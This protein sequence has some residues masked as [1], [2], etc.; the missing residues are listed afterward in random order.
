MRSLYNK[1]LRLLFGCLARARCAGL[2]AWLISR[3]LRRVGNENIHAKYT[4]LMLPRVVFYE[5]VLAAFDNHDEFA[6]VEPPLTMIKALANAFL[7]TQIDTNNYI[8]DDPDVV[9]KKSEYRAFLK[10]VWQ[11]L[12][13]L[14]PLHAV[15]TGNF[16]YYAERELAEGLEELGVPFIAM[17][18]ENL[19]SPGRIA[20]SKDIYRNRRGRFGGRRI[21]VYNDREAR[22]QIDAGVIDAERISVCGMPRLDRIHQWRRSVAGASRDNARRSRVLFF[23]FTGSAV[24]PRIPRRADAGFDANAEPLRDDLRALSWKG[25]AEQTHQ[26]IR[27][28]AEENPDIDVTVKSK[29]RMRERRE[30]HRMLDVANGLPKNLQ[31]VEGGDP[32][33][34]ITTADVVCGFNSTALIESLAAGKSIVIP[35]YAEAKLEHMQQYIV[36]LEDA[37]DY[38]SSPDDLVLRLREQAL[39]RTL[40]SSELDPA[41]KRVLKRWA[42]N[43]D[44]HSGK[45][46]R[47][48]LLAEITGNSG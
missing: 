21:L 26:A 15:V 25:L 47:D 17:H 10:E 28:L 6:I 11:R 46:V 41:R 8:S 12:V 48:T 1:L 31:L 23:S 36:D 38:A 30:M 39:A 18:K 3:T 45:R 5:D 32:F 19:K 2:T 42:G 20:F 40:N 24:L 14:R 13:R 35:R 33:D 16:A 9:R 44:G 37:V 34:L 7:P 29:V 27:R 43:P 4:I 22:L